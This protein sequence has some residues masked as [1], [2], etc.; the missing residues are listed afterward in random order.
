[1]LVISL[2]IL[3]LACPEMLKFLS[4]RC[5]GADRCFCFPSPPQ[6]RE[7]NIAD[8]FEARRA[9]NKA[10]RERKLG[11]REERHAQVRSAARRSNSPGTLLQLFRFS[12]CVHLNAPHE[13]SMFPF[14]SARR[15]RWRLRPPRAR[16]KRMASGCADRADLVGTTVCSTLLEE[17]SKRVFLPRV[18]SVT[19]RR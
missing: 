2:G 1:M 14:S 5:R 7:K 6:A 10:T 13:L 17:L 8:Q 12:P 19:C 9:K 15:G 4:H 18:V 11:R 16:S 3:Q